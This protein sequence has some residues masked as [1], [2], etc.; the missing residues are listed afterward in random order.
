MAGDY[1]RMT[2]KA[3]GDHA[4]VMMQQG[5][6]MLD[7]DWNEQVELL[8]RRLRA[9]I[10]DTLGR[11]VTSAETPDAF[12]IALAAGKL[13]IAPGRAYVHGILAEN[14]GAAPPEYDPVLGELRGT[15]PIDYDAQPYLPNAGA[16][17]PL[18]SSGTYVA[19]LDV[20]EREVTYL[21]DPELVEKAIALDTSARLQVAWQVRLLEAPDG[22]TC[23]SDFPAWDTLTAPSAGRLSTGAVG[24]PA[25]TDPCTIPPAGGYRGTEN[26]LYRIEIHDP[27]PLGTATFKWSVDNASVASHVR[28]IDATGTV[29]GVDRLGRDGVKR[30]GVGDWVEVVDDWLEL[31]GLAGELRKVSAID[32]VK[33]SL[34]LGSSLTAGK[35]DAT[36][37]TRHT[38]VVRW[39]QKGAD[40][41]AAG[42]KITVPAAGPASPITLGDGVQISFDTDAGGDFHSGDWWVF[43]SRT[44]DASVEILTEEPPRGVEHHFCRLAVVTFPDSIVDCRKPP[45]DGGE[46][47]C[48]C[49]VCVTPESHASGTLTIQKAVDMVRVP[50]GKVCLQPGIYRLRETVQLIGA[51]SVEIQG[52][53]WKTI[54]LGPARAP[55]FLVERSAGVIIDMLTVV[56]TT[57]AKPAAVPTGIAILLRNT[58]GTVIERCVLLQL[59]Q[60]QRDPPPPPGDGTPGT[61]QDP[62][63]PDT[64]R[65]ASS[66]G[67]IRELGALFGPRGAGGPL[68]ALDG[69]VIE[70]LIVQNVL[71]GTTG[72][73]PVWAQLSKPLQVMKALDSLAAA[74]EARMSYLLTF[75][76][77]IEENLLIC[78]LTGVSLEGFTLDL[79]TTRIADNSVFV[80]VRAAIVA[81][82]LGGPGARTDVSGNVARVIGCGI[83]VGA[84]DTRVVDNDVRL[85]R[86]LGTTAR[87]GSLVSLPAALGSSEGVA[88]RYLRLFG[89]D[90]ILLTP[91]LRPTAIARCQVRGNRAVDVVGNGIA[92]RAQVA[93][94]SIA[95]NMVQEVGG[96]GVLMAGDVAAQVLEVEQ[97]QVLRVALL[98]DQRPDIAAGILLANVTEL[99]VTGN[100][101]EEV[102]VDGEGALA[103]FGIVTS[104]CRSIRISANKVA[105]VGPPDEFLG[106]GAGI[107]VLDAFQRADVLDNAVRRSEKLDGAP[108]SGEWFGILIAG[109]EA[110]KAGEL[111]RFTEASGSFTVLGTASGYTFLGDVGRVIRF[112]RARE[113]VGVRGNVVEAY[114]Q[115]PAVMIITDAACIFGENRCL[116]RVREG[117]PA[118][119][120][121][122]G[123][124]VAPNNYLQ[125]PLKGTAFE[126]QLPAGGPYTVLGNIASGPIEVDGAVLP[127]PWQPLNIT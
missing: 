95:D 124:V 98:Q 50:G 47:C 86:G 119:R 100:V 126:L 1:T 12:L 88:A 115:V 15:A 21:E 59:P 4:G 30:I 123:A 18:P 120:I 42:G 80:G 65:A 5:R 13:T 36:D 11:C 104:R 51:G 99:S 106:L 53:G 70:T 44:A 64:L 25:P 22:T 101:V 97:N 29:V 118:A 43:A 33:Q 37:A 48:D 105:D 38:R 46:Q 19:Y 74:T 40:V 84:D 68:I 108:T 121:E 117:V 7:A 24:V 20:W 16:V 122:A 14:H 9:E 62:C 66:S 94:A 6:V 91:S 69:I 76:L 34:T 26:R 83:A 8:D 27:G 60:F 116:A 85:L 92:I 17:A 93:S 52:K 113:T 112:A 56:A 87:E 39:D 10:V 49:T 41:D 107:A 57:S 71:L 77:A 79:G 73:G 127:A 32:E 45:P 89:G 96:A 78:W 61:P 90:A 2:F 72:I 31:N 125:G 55:A 102:G 109:G 63:P 81:A 35:F 23:D 58:I 103:R 67:S 3:G 111:G 82:G 114:G 110:T 54:V 75:D 28:T